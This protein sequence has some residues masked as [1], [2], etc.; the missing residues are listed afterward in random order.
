MRIL[1][2]YILKEMLK[3]LALALAA[4]SAVV[5]FG[6]VLAALQQ[7]GLGPLTSLVYM[8]LSVPVAV[9]IALPLAAVLAAT[10]IYG[11]LAADREVM[12]CWAS[13]IPA[14]SLLWP[15]LLLALMG[16]GLSLALAAWPLPQSSYAAKCLALADIERHFFTQLADGHIN[17]KE[18][19]VQLTVDRVA[20]T[21]LYGPTVKYRSPN[22]Q[23]YCYARYGRVEFNA[24]RNEAKLA[25]WDA[26]VVD[27]LHALPVRGTHT[28]TI[29]LPT[30]VP[31]KEDDLTLWH[32]MLIQA[33]PELADRV[34][35]LKEGT[36]EAAVQYFKDAV[37]AAC[38]AEMHKRLAT[39]LGCAGL[40]LVGA[41][42]GLRFHSGHLLTAFGVA[43]AP[44]LGSWL[45]TWVA[46]KAASRAVRNPE[47]LMW[48]IWAPNVLV[49][50]LGLAALAAIAWV[51]AHPVRLRDRLLGRR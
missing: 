42:L 7:K 11:R 2:S 50:L 12:A 37:R 32:L 43:L 18:A 30:F 24:E 34:R 47:D 49:A 46:E 31:R 15:A 16:G 33:H 13:G 1:H 10:L 25:L 29:P 28:L 4:V 27:E 40:V 51:W 44:W 23:T 3:A 21:T 26:M 19:S 5:C 9:Y 45:M 39:A 22:G 48:I 35:M 17:V 14:S 36:P 38:M 6:L 8:A 20:G 41:G